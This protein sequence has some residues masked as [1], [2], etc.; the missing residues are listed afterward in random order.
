MEIERKFTVT[1]LPDLKEYK[2]LKIQQ[3]YLCTEPVVRIR[4][5]GEK[6]YMTYKGKGF[7]EREEYNLP[8]TRTA[9]E[10]LLE[11]ADGNVITK[12]R[13]LIPYDSHTIELDIFEGVFQG[14]IIA[15]VEFSSRSEAS[16]F[17]PPEWFNE[18]VTYKPEYHNSYLSSLDIS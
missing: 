17:A 2:F 11:K 8:L 4:R 7:L 6:Y 15:E 9:Y 5:E 14:L 12:N 10:H 3:A 18:D 1:A 13:Y 16:L